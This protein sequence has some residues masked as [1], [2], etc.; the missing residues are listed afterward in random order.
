MIVACCKQGHDE[1][2]LNLYSE[3]KRSGIVLDHFALARF[4]PTCG[5]MG[6]VE[7][8]KEVHKEISTIG[9]KSNLFSRNALVDM[10]IKC[11][12]VEDAQK[13]FDEMPEW[14]VVPWNTM[15]AR[16]CTEW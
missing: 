12:N 13:L 3:M 10:C 7:E 16:F 4:L 9:Y 5:N 6:A 1:E 11:G 14:N 15:I 2:A 8:G